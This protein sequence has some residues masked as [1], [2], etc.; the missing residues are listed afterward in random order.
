MV[1]ERVD[2]LQNELNDIQQSIFELKKKE[3]ALI[4]DIQKAKQKLV[5][6]NE[7]KSKSF[8]ETFLNKLEEN[9]PISLKRWD[10]YEDGTN[11]LLQVIIKVISERFKNGPAVKQLIKKLYAEIVD[12]ICD[13][14]RCNTRED[15]DREIRGDMDE[16][17]SFLTKVNMRMP[18][19]RAALCTMED[20]MHV[21]DY[22][23]KTLPDVIDEMEL[24]KI[25]PPGHHMRAKLG[26]NIK[27]KIVNEKY[28]DNS[29]FD[30]DHV[31]VLYGK[32]RVLK[33][34]DDELDFVRDE[35]K[36]AVEKQVAG[37]KRMRTTGESD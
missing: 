5:I 4:N 22:D 25:L 27:K 11:D 35:I 32:I 9:T 24:S 10:P 14:R 28:G 36:S 1:S 33:Y 30:N 21:G 7:K 23:G 15:P 19:E 31:K 20:V 6:Y 3:E 29:K 26:Y 16:I 12:I 18:Q 8:E 17:I 2:Q 13:E 34:R 37:V